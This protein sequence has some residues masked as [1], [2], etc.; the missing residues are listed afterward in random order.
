[1]KILKTVVVAATLMFAPIQASSA[2]Y[3]VQNVMDDALYGAGVGA[4][5]GLG[6]LLLSDVPSDNFGYISRGAG[7]GIIAGAA[8]GVFRSSRSF[9]QVEDG[10]IYLGVPS[11]EFALRET[12]A[13]LDLVM[14]TDL[15]RGKF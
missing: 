14:K 3:E 4:M 12:A 9:A 10:E 6:L 1:M 11:P 7:I 2:D 15:I 13:G 8:Y 5:V